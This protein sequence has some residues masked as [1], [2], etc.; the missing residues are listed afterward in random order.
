VIHAIRQSDDRTGAMFRR[1]L[2]G[3]TMDLLE[4]RRRGLDQPSL[5][6]G[7]NKPATPGLSGESPELTLREAVLSGAG[8]FRRPGR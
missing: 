7:S 3:W 1:Y 8:S 2:S 6:G 5:R 4:L